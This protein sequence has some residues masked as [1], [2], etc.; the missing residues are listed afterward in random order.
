MKYEVEYIDEEHLYLVNGVIVPSVT[1]I[2]SKIFPNK[3]SNVPKE[4]LDKKASFGSHIH[5]YIEQYENGVIT[6]QLNY[7]EEACFNQYLRLKDRNNIKVLE[8]EKIVN[9]KNIYAGRFDMIANINGYHSLADIKTTASL[10][11]EYLSWQLSL[12]E[13][14]MGIEFEKFYVIWLPKKNIGKLVEIPKK[15]KEEILNLLNELN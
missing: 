9:Y 13:F 12:Y 2:L 3:Y 6:M 4:V 5:N 8:Q 14:A 15:S 1:Q 10:D 11:K 7:I